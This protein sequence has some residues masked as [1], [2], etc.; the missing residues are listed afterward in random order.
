M[1]PTLVLLYLLGLIAY[2]A[3]HSRRIRTQEDFAVAGRSLAAPIVLGTMLATWIGTGSLLGNAQKTYEAGLAMLLIPLGSVVGLLLLTQI[4][5]RVRG[6]AQLTLQ[7]MIEVR[8]GVIPR[9]FSTLALLSA[10]MIIVSYQYRAG[11]GV[12]HTMFP[13]LAEWCNATFPGFVAFMKEHD[14]AW[15]DA[16]WGSVVAALFII[17]YTVLG[18]LVSVAYTDVINGLVM[19]L[20]IVIGLPILYVK[21]G[22]WGGIETALAATPDRM[23]VVGPFG[24]IDYINFA[25]PA[26]LLVMGDA[27]VYQ[28]FFAARTAAVARSAA[29]WLVPAVFIVEVLIILFAFVGLALEPNLTGTDAKHVILVVAHRHLYPLLAAGVLAAAVA[30]IVS[31][32]DSFLLVSANSVVRDVYQRLLNPGATPGGLVLVSRIAVVLLGLLA[33]FVSVWSNDFFNMALLAYTI[34]GASITPVLLALFFWKRANGAGAT[35]GIIGG[36]TA[37]IVWDR[38]VAG[39]TLTGLAAQFDAVLPAMLVAV[40]LLVIVS[41]LTPPPRPEQVAMRRYR[42]GCCRSCGYDLSGNTS[43]TCPEC[44]ATAAEAG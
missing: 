9:L 16:S 29:I 42:A 36:V 38:M 11:G 25:L 8:F 24:W 6:I 21:V 10:Y 32:A 3:W 39:G 7:D 31:T 22:G 18:G 5:A 12:I 40:A 37:T 30:I 17:G 35:A 26:M 33:F 20:G 1:I 15:Q 34:Y 14:T 23:Q 19:I 41:L 4:A 27:N 43:G 13:E 2:G 44:G 28:R